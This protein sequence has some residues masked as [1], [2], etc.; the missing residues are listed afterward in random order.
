[1]SVRVPVSVLNAID[2]IDNFLYENK[3]TI[4]S[5]AQPRS[6]WDTKK[7]VNDRVGYHRTAANLVKRSLA[8]VIADNS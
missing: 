2:T 1:M 3:R 7:N 4:R 6:K 8:G 5:V